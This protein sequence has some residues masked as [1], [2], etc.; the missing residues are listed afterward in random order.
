MNRIAVVKELASVVRELTGIER[1]RVAGPSV[2]K[3]FKLQRNGVEIYWS[4]RPG[5]RL[6]V[7]Q[8]ESW[9]DSTKADA[10]DDLRYLKSHFKSVMMESGTVLSSHVGISI[11][12]VAAATILDGEQ[13]NLLVSLDRLQFNEIH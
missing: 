5:K 9:I 13:G 7:K 6:S 3:E 11:E 2:H 4:A 12:F 8:M 10:K 1:K